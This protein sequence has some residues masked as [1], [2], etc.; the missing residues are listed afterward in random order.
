MDPF[1]Y[2]AYRLSHSHPRSRKPLARGSALFSLAMG[3][4]LLL[5]V[6]FVVA[7]VAPRWFA[8]AVCIVA[9]FGAVLVYVVARA[10]TSANRSK[11]AVLASRITSARPHSPKFTERCPGPLDRDVSP[12]PD[13]RHE[14]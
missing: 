14:G 8:V 4:L 13:D 9:A 11:S 6:S 12:C 3:M 1:S 5:A 7:Q 2:Q 10:I